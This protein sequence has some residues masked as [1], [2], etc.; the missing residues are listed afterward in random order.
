MT[1]VLTSIGIALLALAA[2]PFI[3]YPL[4][5]MLMRRRCAPA[6]AAPQP[7]ERPSVAICLSA[8]NEAAVIVEKVESLLAMAKAYGPATIH[9]YV[10]GAE[11]ETATLLKSY[12]DRVDL[13]VSTERRGKTAGMN[14]LVARS[15]SALIAFTDAN[16][17]I[18]ADGLVALAAPFADDTIGCT[19]AR[20]HYS[21]PDQSGTS[22]AGATYW[23]L[24]ETIKQL[25]TDT[26]GLVG[27]DG[28]FFMVRRECYT[29]APPYLIDDLYVTLRILISGARLVSVPAATVSERNAALWHEEFRRKIRI[30]CQA[31]NVHRALWPQLRRMPA[32]LLYAY[33][34]HRL[35]KWMLPFTA[36]GA[37][38]VLGGALATVI[39]SATVLLLAFGGGAA[40]LLGAALGL[41]PC[42]V[43]ATSLAS[44]AGV[45]IGV[46]QSAFLQRTYTVWT[47]AASIREPQTAPPP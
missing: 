12:E 43:A 13:V 24:E 17:A 5:L 40:I 7:D 20:L 36:A 14:L 6:T 47:P 3:T 2:H 1:A 22:A 9:I 32:L 27:V 26:T 16:V 23:R 42:A 37:V 28:A 45:G 8:F 39:G 19:S 29:P 10:D 38:I 34:S 18:P 4:S 46:L 11:D 31:F 41:R 33:L 25:E 35:L 21:N 30:A 44:L 15:T